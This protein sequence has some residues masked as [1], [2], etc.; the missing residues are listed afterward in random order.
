MA[1]EFGEK[2]AIVM[3]CVSVRLGGSLVLENASAHVPRG[4]STAIIGPNGAGKTSLALAI[5]GQEPYSGTIHF[6]PHRTRNSVRF[7][8]VPQKLQFDR[9]MPMTVLD[10]LTAGLQRRPLFFGYSPRRRAQALAML[11][12]VECVELADRSFGAL[13]GGEIQRVLLAS[14]LLRDPEIL[15][16]DEPTSGVDFK[17]GRL[18]CELLH[19]IRAKRHFSQVMIS[20]D[21]ATVAA[22]ATHVICL[23]NTVIAEGA[24]KAIL[25]HDVLTK[26]FGLHLG[27]PDLHALAGNV[28][29]CD[30]SCPHH[31]EHAACHPDAVSC[32]CH[33]HGTGGKDE[34]TC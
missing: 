14:A 23:N 30:E 18:C 10:F 31:A 11:E 15:I 28:R 5:L 21:L 19:R 3:E 22:H 33:A 4:E 24:P 29:L 26:T 7:G 8:F 32:S 2:Y 6:P 27:V 16:L 34:K 1:E 9:A 25:T 17:G 20:H 13:S 12:E